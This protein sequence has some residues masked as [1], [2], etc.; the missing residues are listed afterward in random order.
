APRVEMLTEQFR[1]DESICRLISG[2]F[3]G[4][5]LS[6]SRKQNDLDL[7]D[8][9]A[10]RLTIV[11]TSRVWPFTT[12]DTFNSRLNLM[13]ALAIRNLMFHLHE[14]GCVY[15]IDGKGA[16]GVCTP[17]AAQAGLLQTILKAHG[18]VNVRG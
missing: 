11:D 18:C 14:H 6:T 9:F 12:R 17:Y 5:H 3:Y 13:H 4:G 8:P 2:P 7:P 16:V 10:Q 1:M 15:D